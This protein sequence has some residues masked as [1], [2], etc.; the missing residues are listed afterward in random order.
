MYIILCMQSMQVPGTWRWMLGVAGLPAVIQFG[1]MIYLPES[2]RWLYLNVINQ[3]IYIHAYI[4]LTF[5]HIYG[6]FVF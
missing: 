6:L 5:I 1:L 3:N 4:F 2:P